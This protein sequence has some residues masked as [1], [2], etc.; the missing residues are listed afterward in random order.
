MPIQTIHIKN[1]ICQSCIKTVKEDLIN[2]GLKVSSVK[3]GHARFHKNPEVAMLQIKNAL[4][5]DGFEVIEDVDEQLVEEIKHFIIDLIQRHPQLLQE[6]NFPKYLSEKI[7]KPYRNL[8]STF[9]AKKKMTIEHYIILIKIERTKELLE[10]GE[11]NLSE[12]SHHLG[13]K[14][15]QHLSSQF[16]EITGKSAAEYQKHKIKTRKGL[17]KI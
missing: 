6:I 13:Y 3:M 14:T 7:K 16:H 15:L 5:A 12:I 8:S 17:D 4:C 1:M 11:M 9:S 10:Y 2:L